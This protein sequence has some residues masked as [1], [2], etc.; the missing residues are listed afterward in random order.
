VL[1]L[2]RYE[3]NLR[4]E[5]AAT[6]SLLHL[7][8]EYQ[9]HATWAIVGFLFF[10]RK[11]DL[12]AQLPSTQPNYAN[13]AFSPYECL[14]DI[15][16][17]ENEDPLHL[18]AS[19]VRMI[20]ANE[21]QEI[22]THT[23]SHFYCLERGQDVTA[24]TADL[25]SALAAARLHKLRID[26]IVFPRNQVNPDYLAACREAGIRAYRGTEKHWLY[27]PR[28]VESE[29]SLR[30]GARLVDAYLNLTGHHTVSLKSI[31]RNIPFNIAQSRFLRPYSRKLAILEPLRL[32][33]ILTGL[34]MAAQRREM[35]HLW[36]HP[37]NFG[38]DL[39]KNLFFLRRILEHF[40]Q[41]RDEYGMESLNMR[42][43]A[44]RLEGDA[45]PA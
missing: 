33:R 9:I 37:H 32:R 28:S 27:A 31:G 6:H 30:R 38:V 17:N 43:L 11:S 15:G 12:L 26:S 23:F 7:F 10:E 35:Y 19:L 18:G 44:Q 4:G 24:F 13:R 21:H 20:V 14:G 45:I 34:N 5:R 8:A 36:W 2:T 3:T 25:A 1:P 40:R 42:E 29:S 41:L 22:A 39:D 16:N